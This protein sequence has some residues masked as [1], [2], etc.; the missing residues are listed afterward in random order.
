MTGLLDR[1][2]GI[3]GALRLESGDRWGDVARPFQLETARQVL[4]REAVA[5]YSFTVR[6][7][8]GSKTSDLAGCATAQLLT[9]PA[10]AR[11]YWAAADLDQAT[12]GLDAIAGFQARTPE[13]AGA[14]EVQAR[15]VVAVATGATLEF[16]PADESGSWGL[17]PLAVFVHELA[18]WADARGPRRLLTRS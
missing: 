4:D 7:R 3:L 18:A 1:R 17:L 15:R 10:R 8:G 11:L 14:L 6:A 9:A 5:P 16:L 12:L 13:V 2:L